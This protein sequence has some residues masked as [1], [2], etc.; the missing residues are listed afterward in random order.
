MDFTVVNKETEKTFE[1]L[2]RRIHRLQSGGTLDSLK[3]IGAST[4]K[5]IGASYVSLKQLANSYEPN[6]QLAWLLWNKQK[7]EEQIIACML[8]PPDMN[9]EKITQL[10]PHCLHFEI[11]GYLGSL[12]LYK[13]PDLLELA[14]EWL[15]SENPFMQLAIMTALARYLIL[16]KESDKISKDYFRTVVNRNYKDKYVQLAAER[17]RFNI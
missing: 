7:R 2:L 17:Y 12:Y 3:D 6:E 4:E 15:N 16:N 14:E 9:K 1:E 13:R 10:A 11:A 8:F 5:Q